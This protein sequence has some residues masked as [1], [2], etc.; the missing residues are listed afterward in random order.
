MNITDSNFVVGNGSKKMDIILVLVCFVVM[1]GF[2]QGMLA[3]ADPEQQNKIAG[4]G[5]VLLFLFAMLAS[6]ASPV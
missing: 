6:L 1:Y 3:A 2:Y 5:L 4:A